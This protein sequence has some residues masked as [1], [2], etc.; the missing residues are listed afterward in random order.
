MPWLHKSSLRRKIMLVIMINTVG[1]LCVAGIG[2]AEYGVH[3]FKQLHMEDLNALADVIG[4]N[5]MAPLVFRD[6]NA[7]SDILQALAAKPHIL[8]ACVYDRD[9]CAR[10]EGR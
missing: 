8:A 5:T 6:S 7:A 10:H 9:D 2:F 1:T 3:R 4:A